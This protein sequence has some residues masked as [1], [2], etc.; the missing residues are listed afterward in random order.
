MESADIKKD[1]FPRFPDGM[2]ALEVWDVF[3]RGREGVGRFFFFNFIAPIKRV[4]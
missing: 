1:F 3:G 4:A 2:D